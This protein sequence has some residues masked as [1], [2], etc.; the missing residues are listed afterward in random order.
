M[1]LCQFKFL[2][3]PQQFELINKYAVPVVERTEGDYLY[4]LLYIDSFYIEQK[5]DIKL[6]KL[7]LYTPFNSQEKLLPYVHIM[8][9]WQLK[10][11]LYRSY[12]I[13]PD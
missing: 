13:K 9:L 7:L 2:E 11:Q 8:D 10:Y 1:T 3:T 4:K 5:W 6:N 12:T